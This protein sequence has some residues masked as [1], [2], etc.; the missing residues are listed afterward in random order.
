MGTGASAS[1]ATRLNIGCV[2]IYPRRLRRALAC[3]NSP[4]RCRLTMI[5]AFHSIF[6]MY[7]LWMPN[8]PRGSGTD[9]VAVWELFRY[10]PA[11]KVRTRH[12]V[13]AKPHD[14]AQRFAA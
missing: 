12:S 8:D 7:G 5:L 13:A 1:Q 14:R 4:P 6:S 9:Y 3:P 11:T 10:G 2:F